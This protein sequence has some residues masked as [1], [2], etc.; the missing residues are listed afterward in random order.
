MGLWSRPLGRADV[1]A[2]YEVSAAQ[3]LVD[4]GEIVVEEAEIVADW[5]R[6]TFDVGE[7]TVGVFAGDRL[8]GYAEVTSADRGDAA[9]HPEFRGRGVGRWLAEWMQDTARGRGRACGRDARTA[10]LGW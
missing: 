3:G 9:V 5:Q 7:C 8:V 1:R 2:V 4:V 10:G 6:P